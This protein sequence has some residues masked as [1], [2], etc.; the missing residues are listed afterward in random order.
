MNLAA[1]FGPVEGLTTRIE[2]T[3]LL[4]LTS[5]PGQ[6]AHVDRIQ[7][8]IDVL[9]GDIRFQLQ[10]DYRVAIEG[11]RWPFSGGLLDLE[12][13]V[14]DFS[15]ETTKYLTF[16]V[17]GLDAARFV[18]QM[19]FSNI[20][21]TGTFD[22]IIPMQFDEEGAGHILGGR[23][24]ARSDGGTLSYVGELTDRDLG[25]YGILAFN[26]LKS[27]RYSR[28]ALT[29]NGELD[30]EFITVIDLDG[31]A[32][33]PAGTTVPGGGGIAGLVVGRVFRQISRIPFEFNITIQG[34]F[35]SL[36]ATTRSFSDPTPLIES[37]LPQL[38][39]EREQN[40]EQREND[41]QDEE[42]EPVP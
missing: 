39:R 18:E 9:D 26:A 10:P 6:R 8:G 14:L 38:L 34:Q 22:G 42:S 12:P 2:F 15:R 17:T 16:R 20:A 13:T 32:R 31:I 40:R 1:P 36:I 25:A 24:S 4:G 27:L 28:F 3:D 5:A 23:L 7:A 30:G 19:E 29:L 41:V 37:V 11:A 35:R 21:A 33:D